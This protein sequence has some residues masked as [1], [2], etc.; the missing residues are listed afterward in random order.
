MGID[1]DYVTKSLNKTN[2]ISSEL[3]YLEKIFQ[4]QVILPPIRKGFIRSELEKLLNVK[5]MAI[6]EQKQFE[7]VFDSL[8]FDQNDLAVSMFS[9]IVF[10][11][12]FEEAISNKRDLIRLVNSFQLSYK[13]LK[14]EVDLADLVLLETIKIKSPSVYQQ[15]MNRSLLSS[16][17][18]RNPKQF[19]IN[20]KEFDSTLGEPNTSDDEDRRIN[21]ELVKT[22][23]ALRNVESERSIVYPHSFDIYFQ[24]ALLNNISIVEYR[25]LISK[26]S[27]EIVAQIR[28][29]YAEN[30]AGSL[31]QI[32][33]RKSV[34]ADR[35]EFVKFIEVFLCL[36]DSPS[37]RQWI[38]HAYSFFTLP[39][40]LEN[41]YHV[42]DEE[43]RTLLQDL[44]NDEAFT[45]YARSEFSSFFLLEALKGSTKFQDADFWKKVTLDLLIKF[46][47][48]HA[49]SSFDSIIYELLSNVI[50]R[51]KSDSKYEI[52]KAAYQ[53]YIQYL[54]DHKPEYAPFI[55][56]P[57]LIPPDE[58]FT[59]D[60]WLFIS[61][62]NDKE[63]LEQFFNSIDSEDELFSFAKKYLPD[64]LKAFEQSEG[65]SFFKVNEEEKERIL[66]LR[67]KFLNN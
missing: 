2:Q 6:D 39:H 3:R 16:S 67:K 54:T 7:Q 38:T 26:S 29:W 53:V 40:I 64:Y 66:E 44:V 32:L 46:A 37:N 24:Y 19:I 20:K 42:T 10:Q 33:L 28:K 30:K 48:K 52:S 61:L 22:L 4:H 45:F 31:D 27:L 36:G 12:P 14:G 57:Y 56:R 25:T 49:E 55:I 11:S 9:E 47:K 51:Y 50:D 1:I 5:S 15:I 41:E 35:N 18:N 59:F 63:K 17:E 13:S 23:F 62:E 21:G 34:F 60:P 8:F 65:H 58:R 43:I